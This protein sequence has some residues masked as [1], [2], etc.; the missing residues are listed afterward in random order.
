[1]LRLKYICR[2]LIAPSAF[3]DLV[4]CCFFWHI[5]APFA[6]GCDVGIFF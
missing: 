6:R 1:M 3:L 4:T 5:H 2:Y